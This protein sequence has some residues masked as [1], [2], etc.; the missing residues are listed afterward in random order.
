MASMTQV[1]S[2]RRVIAFEPDGGTVTLH[3]AKKKKRKKQS[4]WLKPLEKGQ[5]RLTRAIL[6]GAG[7][8]KLRHDRSN[9]KKKDGWMRDIDKN[10][11]K[12]ARKGGKKI[13]IFKL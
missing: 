13:K 8:Y 6:T 9:R 5:R 12:S 7:E 11:S 2:V 1:K 3:T 4:R 10:L